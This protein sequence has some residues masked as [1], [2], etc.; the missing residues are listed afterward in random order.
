MSK[1][2]SSADG[3]WIASGGSD[4]RIRVADMGS[5]AIVTTLVAV[6]LFA[7]TAVELLVMPRYV[8]PNVATHMPITKSD[9]LLLAVV[10]GAA[11]VAIVTTARDE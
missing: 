8:L 6:A 3:R 4:G 1:L 7:G 11:L 9:L 5:G 10:L 2:A